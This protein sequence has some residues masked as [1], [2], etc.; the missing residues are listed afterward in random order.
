MVA[1]EEARALYASAREH[2]RASD[3]HRRE[4]QDAMRRL[5]SFCEA[6]GIALEVIKNEAKET[7]HGQHIPN[8]GRY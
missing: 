3:R 5:A 8:P 7:I 4:A 2:K 6:H 1:R